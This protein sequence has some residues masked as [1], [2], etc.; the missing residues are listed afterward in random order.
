LK[1]AKPGEVVMGEGGMGAPGW[2]AALAVLE[3]EAVTRVYLSAASCGDELLTK[4]LLEG[5]AH[6]GAGISLSEEVA[7]LGGQ[8]EN[9]L[10]MLG[11]IKPKG[12][13]E[14]LAASVPLPGVARDVSEPGIAAAAAAIVGAVAG[15]SPEIRLP[16]RDSPAAK[17]A[18]ARPGSR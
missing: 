2:A 18:G 5:A 4:N 3:E 16:L 12:C 7:I 6:M 13:P 8:T 9:R 10:R 11:V 15:K 1:A 17:K 14:F